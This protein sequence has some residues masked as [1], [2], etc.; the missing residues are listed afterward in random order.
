MVKSQPH[1]QV[2]IFQSNE[3]HVDPT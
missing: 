1:V 2:Q 3:T